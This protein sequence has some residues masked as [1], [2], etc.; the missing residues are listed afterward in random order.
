MTMFSK[1]ATLVPFVPESFVDGK[2]PR[3][4][5]VV[6]EITVKVCAECD[7]ELEYDYPS[8]T[9]PKCGETYTFKG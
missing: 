2:I 4:K 6:R 3:Q 1:K 5:L 9:C 7:T 8:Y